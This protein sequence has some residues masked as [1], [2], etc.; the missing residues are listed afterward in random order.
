[1]A[2]QMPFNL[3]DESCKEINVLFQTAEKLNEV[4]RLCQMIEECGGLDKI[5]ELQNHENESVY[6]K[7]L[8]II[9]THFGEEETNGVSSTANGQA[10]DFSSGN[11][12]PDGGF[13]F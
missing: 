12:L 1:M 8:S 6:K 5:E 4:D 9:E 13:S 11:N 3:Q 10:Y 7:A 2:S